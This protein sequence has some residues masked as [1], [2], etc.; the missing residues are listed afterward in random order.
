M[1]GRAIQKPI[2]FL[3]KICLLIMPYFV[4]F[5]P[6]HFSDSLIFLTSS[7]FLIFM[8]ESDRWCFITS[9]MY[10]CFCRFIIPILCR[11]WIILKVKLRLY[12]SF[13]RYDYFNDPIWKAHTNPAIDKSTTNIKPIN[14]PY[15][16]LCWL[17]NKL[18]YE[19]SCLIS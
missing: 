13:S 15:V 1:S 10:A 8:N 19:N 16:F 12:A 9:S 4:R 5:F 6:Y 7:K 3:L 14:G 18:V 17:P 11:S 2:D